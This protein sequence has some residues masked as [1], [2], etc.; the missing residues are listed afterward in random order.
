MSSITGPRAGFLLRTS[1]RFVYPVVMQSLTREELRLLRSLSTP[2]KIQKFLD[3]LDYH[4][5]DTAWSPRLVLRHRAA[6]CFEGAVLAAAALRVNGYPP[7]IL[8]F[9]AKNDTDHVVA[10]FRQGRGWGAIGVSNYPGC[11]FRDPIY[12][13]L[14]EL[15][16]SY[17]NEYFNH[18]RE[19]TMRT[20]S[21]PVNLKRFDRYNW[22]SSEKPIWYI[23]EYLVEIPH[24]PLLTPEMERL[25]TPL[26]R[27]SFQAGM[28]F[29]LLKK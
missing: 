15:A 20:Y 21:R 13:S 10:V 3:S 26:D 18:R 17:F 24:T 27:R 8:D 19:K 25:L 12:R 16:L 2:A 7:L 6:H 1:S 28:H 14:R 11:R 9:E 4:L 29:R 23:A 22:M 5:T